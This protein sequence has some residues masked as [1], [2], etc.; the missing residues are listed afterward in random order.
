MSLHLHY[1]HID[2]E[3][4]AVTIPKVISRI[5]SAIMSAGVDSSSGGESVATSILP[6]SS[7]SLLDRSSWSIKHVC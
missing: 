3:I 5:Q 2:L 6:L 1:L 4:L 7:L